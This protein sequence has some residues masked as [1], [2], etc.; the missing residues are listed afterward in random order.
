MSFY[1]TRTLPGTRS[2]VVDK[3]SALMHLEHEEW[4]P[5]DADH[6]NLCRFADPQDWGFRITSRC[7]LRFAEAS[8]LNLSTSN[9]HE[10]Y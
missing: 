4:V 5:L 3:M 1:E 7:I 9:G 10:G 8:N 6:I 2:T